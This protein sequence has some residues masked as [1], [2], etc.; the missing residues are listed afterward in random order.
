MPDPY[1][2]A[3]WRFEQIA[4]LV[5]ASL[6]ESARR[7]ALRQRTRTAVEWPGAEERRRRGQA[8]INKRIPKSTLY[9]WLAAYRKD[10]YLGL[11]PKGREDRGKPRHAGTSTWVHYAIALLYEQPER[12]LTQLA[13]YLELQF[14]DY[15]LSRSTLARHLRTHPAYR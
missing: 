1:T 6:D 13:I 7:A 8:P 9:R 2:L 14:D 11:L 3:A 15:A 5:D 4:P 12:S 10:G